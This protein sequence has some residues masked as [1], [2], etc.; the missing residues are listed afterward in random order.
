MFPYGIRFSVTDQKKI[1]QKKR[2]RISEFVVD[3]T[4][5]K[6][7]NE[8]VLQWIA[9]EPSDK[10]ILDIRILIERNMLVAEQFLKNSIRK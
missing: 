7:G 5:V 2:I 8:Y 4:L 9:I 10:I 1:F 6:T 3:E